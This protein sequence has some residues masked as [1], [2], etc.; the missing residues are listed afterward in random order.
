MR[1][2]V[3]VVATLAVVLLASLAVMAQAQQTPPAD[4]PISGEWD[5]VAYYDSE[6]AFTLALK[7]EG[8]DVKGTA[9]TPEGTSDLRNG[10]WDA[11]V[12]SFELL[13]QGA[14][15]AMSASIKEG[16]LVG[17]WTY[18]SGEASGRWQATRRAPK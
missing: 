12:F 4:D 15:V 13:Y 17:S 3:S 10:R 11:G 18:G 5:A 9:T 16:Q 1:R 7:L 14:P 6:V 8:A 2:L